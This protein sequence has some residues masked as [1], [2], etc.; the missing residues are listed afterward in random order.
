MSERTNWKLFDTCKKCDQRTGQACLDLRYSSDVSCLFRVTPHRERERLPSQRRSQE[1]NGD[2]L[3]VAIL[4]EAKR[5]GMSI[6]ALSEAAEVSHSSL[7][8]NA[9]GGTSPRLNMLRKLLKVI[10]CDVVLVPREES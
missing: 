1:A 6:L 5:Q 4:S 8:S 7:S 3:V 10:H 2:P 9:V